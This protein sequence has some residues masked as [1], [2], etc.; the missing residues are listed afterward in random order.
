MASNDI[1]MRVLLNVEGK[2]TVVEVSGSVKEITGVTAWQRC[3]VP[4]RR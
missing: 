4:G 2:N 1:R 3:D